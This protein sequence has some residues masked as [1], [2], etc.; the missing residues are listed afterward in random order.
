MIFTTIDFDRK[1]RQHGFL[2]LPFSYNL[3]GWANLMIPIT[4]LSGGSGPTALILAGTHGDEYPGQ[5]AVSRLAHRLEV[6]KVK[7]RLILIPTINQPAA[8][9]STRLSPLDGKNLNRAFPGSPE[10]S[11]TD[12]IADYL[13]RVLFPMADIV[14]DIHT[15]GRGM[16][17]YPCTCMDL[18]SDKRQLK[19]M[20][21]A[22]LAWNTDFLMLYLTNIAGTGLLPVEAERQG[23]IV[24]TT[25]LGGG[26]WYPADVHRLTQSGLQ[27][28]LIHLGVIAGKE[29]TRASLG[30]PPT[31]LVRSLNKQ[32][33]VMAPESG[34]FESLVDLGTR[35]EVGQPVGELHFLERPDRPAE[36]ITAQSA[37]YVICFRSPCRTQ[38]GDCLAVTAQEVEPQSL[39]A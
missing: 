24:V 8:R 33:Y 26:E 21:E 12:Q 34:F 5:I 17:F 32:D 31:R 3:A 25:E 28:V 37:G 36:V 29:E 6:E 18:V 11:P 38:Q 22:T 4:V 13:T 10:G 7:G 9:A 1:G 30:K 35:V 23:K 15:G 20:L 39:F 27:N 16:K 14:I 2:Q 19:T